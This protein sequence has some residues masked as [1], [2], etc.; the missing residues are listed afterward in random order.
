MMTRARTT[1]IAHQVAAFL[2]KTTGDALEFGIRAWDGSIVGAESGSALVLTG[3]HAVRRMLWSPGQLGAARA[4]VAGDIAIEGDLVAVMRQLGS[5]MG[6][7]RSDL[8]RAALSSWRLA[9]DRQVLGPPLRP[10]SG[11]ARPSRGARAVRHHYDV[12]DD[13][14]R[15]VLGS[16]MVYS[17]AYWGQGADLAGFELD[18]AQSSK[19]E[20]I[21]RKLDLQPGMRLLDL[22][23]GWGSLLLHAARHHGVDGVGVTLSPNQARLAT[24]RFQEAGLTDRLHVRLQ[25]YRAVPDGP[26]DAVASVEMTQH[27]SR[28]GQREHVDA[29][30]RL[31][32][33]GGRVLS[34]ELCILRPGRR[35]LR[36]PFILRYV[37]PDFN[38][39]EIGSSVLQAERSGLEVLDVENLRTDFALTLRAWLDRLEMR[40]ERA[41]ELVGRETVAVWRLLFAAGL[42]SYEAGLLNLQHMVCVRPHPVKRRIFTPQPGCYR[43]PVPSTTGVSEKVPVASGDG[44]AP[45]QRAH[46]PL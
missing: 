41:V 17:S 30:A 24:R 39:G 33:P 37:F 16:S 26:F 4:F 34:H 31:V 40:H 28:R 36:S 42:L 13:F 46:S 9:V 44:R 27:L 29:L 20:L 10:P 45:G 14:Y 23:C 7:S 12:G 6:S 2:E 18:D 21:C 5:V 11:E 38:P 35:L 32:V 19:L 3:P 43:R 15:L 22:G 1:G 25:D 8:A